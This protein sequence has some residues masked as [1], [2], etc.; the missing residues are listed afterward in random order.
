MKQLHGAAPV[1]VVADVPKSIDYHRDALGFH[2]E[3]VC[4]FWA[5]SR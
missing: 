2:M 1:F 4:A 3:F 5:G